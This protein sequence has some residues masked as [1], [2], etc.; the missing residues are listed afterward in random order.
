MR[1]PPL[2]DRNEDTLPLIEMMLQQ[3][4][5]KY[6]KNKSFTPEAIECLLNYNWPGNIRELRNIVERMVVISSD[7]TIG[8]DN[9]PQALYEKKNKLPHGLLASNKL[10]EAVEDVEKYI[11]TKT[12]RENKSLRKTASI[13][14]VDHS[15][16]CRK[17]QRYQIPVIYE[18]N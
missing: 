5:K 12:I 7:E 18:E 16:I 4:N 10:K 8:V 17:V 14:G 1:I 3:L 13:L 2:R 11:L 15:T 6:G 9:L